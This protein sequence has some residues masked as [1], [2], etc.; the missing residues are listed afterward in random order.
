M[1]NNIIFL[2]NKTTP[3]DKY[4]VESKDNKYSDVQFLPLIAHTHHPVEALHLLK[5]NNYISNL[6]YLIVTSQRTVECLNESIIPTLTKEQREKLLD[7]SVYTVGPATGDF[8]RRVGF[9]NVK[10]DDMGNGDKLSDFII[11]DIGDN[12]DGE[13]LSF[14]GAIRRDIIKNKLKQRG[15]SVKEVVTYETN[16]LNDNLDRFQNTL[17]DI[18]DKEE[19]DGKSCCWVVIFSPQGAKD[20]IKFLKQ[21]PSIKDKLDLRISCIGPTT[22]DYLLDNGINPEV[23]SP[24]PTP[25]SLLDAIDGFQKSMVTTVKH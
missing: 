15:L 25:D 12:Y 5:D 17:V 9:R 21:N 22:N 19:C 14:V 10:G 13:I 2:K 4:E 23:V 24:Q 6:R 3:L 20:I 11:K 8:L 1:S 18:A 16:V 7:L